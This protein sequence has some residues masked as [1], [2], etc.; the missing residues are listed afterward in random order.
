MKEGSKWEVILPPELA[1]GK[2][3]FAPKIG[4]NQTL[5]FEIERLIMFISAMFKPEANISSVSFCKS[6]KSTPSDKTSTKLEAPPE[7][8]NINS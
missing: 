3:G 5:I 8:K 6:D 4:P 2:R 7:I 1:Y